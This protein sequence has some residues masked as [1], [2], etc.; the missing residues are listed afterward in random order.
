MLIKTSFQHNVH[1]EVFDHEDIAF[2]RVLGR[3][4]EGVVRECTVTYNDLPVD[5]AVKTLLDNSDDCINITLDEIELLWC[6][7][8]LFFLDFMHIFLC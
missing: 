3:G 5:G 2:G 4:G 8:F 7:L 6:V 1:L